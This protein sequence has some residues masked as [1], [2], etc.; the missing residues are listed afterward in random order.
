MNLRTLISAATLGNPQRI[1]PIVIWTFLE[2]M[3]RGSPYGILLFVVL[4]FFRPLQQSPQEIRGWAIGVACASLAVSMLLL[5]YVGRKAYFACYNGSY[6]LCAEGRMAI[7]RHLNRLPMGFYNSR[8]PGDIGAYLV[9]DYANVEFLISHLLPQF[10]GAVAMPLVLLLTLSCYDLRLAFAAAAVIPLALPFAWISV[11]LIRW[12]GITHQ[13]TKVESIARM[14]EYI[15]G[16]KLIKAFN[17]GGTKFTRLESAFRRLRDESIRLEGGAGPTILLSSM[18]LHLGL[19]ILILLGLS[20]WLSGQVALPVYILFL[21]LGGRIYEPLFHALL[22][23]GEINY[24]NLGVERIER[25][26]RTPPLP[27]QAAT[28]QVENHGIR[29][30][31]VCFAY[32]NAQVL[33]NFNLE[34]APRSLTAL[35]GPSGSGKT[36]VTRLIAR[37]WDV[38]EGCIELCGHDIRNLPS[39]YLLAQISMVF[40]DVYLFNDTIYHNIRIGRDNATRAEIEA[41]AKSARCHDFIM[42]LPKGYDTLVGEGGSTLSGGEKQRISIARA[43][44]KDAPIVMLDEAT[45]SLDPENEWHIQQAIEELIRN[46]TVIVIAHRLQTIARADHIAVMDHGRVIQSGKH[47]ELL[48]RGGLYRNLWDQQQRCQSWRFG[49]KPSTSPN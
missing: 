19:P 46:R 5:Y 9:T 14:L 8:D 4:E 26:H 43:I 2:Y 39:D 32:N 15:Q 37:F 6:A 22:F 25:L 11:K 35:V 29:F 38:D 7:A 34:I 23:L 12:M 30:R 17:L 47:H 28:L 36:T 41:A 27:E 31:N 18:V 44:L 45:A 49:A 21:V 20:F 24:M 42:A 33:D 13:R 40:Q 1:R 10:V 16:I 48:E 3:L